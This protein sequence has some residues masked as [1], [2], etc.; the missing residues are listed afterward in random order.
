MNKRGIRVKDNFGRSLFVGCLLVGLGSLG[1]RASAEDLVVARGE[2][3]ELAESKT[4]DTITVHGRL[5]VSGGA[6]VGA[7]TVALGP[8]AGDE[9]EIAVLDASSCF[10]T[11][12]TTK[13]TVG[14]NG[15]TGCLVGPSVGGGGGKTLAL[16][17]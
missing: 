5:T 4:F 10:G 17:I 16:P 8:D 12:K 11:A 9:A 7:A 3:V 1:L 2:T 14:S 13:I 6:T 15:G